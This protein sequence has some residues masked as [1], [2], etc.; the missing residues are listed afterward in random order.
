MPLHG[1]DSLAT[2]KIPNVLGFFTVKRREREWPLDK[3]QS[4]LAESFAAR[5]VRERGE[6]HL[7]A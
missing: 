4:F 1:R 2:L 5:R 7:P 6:E 3:A